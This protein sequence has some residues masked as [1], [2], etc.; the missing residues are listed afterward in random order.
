MMNRVGRIRTTPRR[1][2]RGGSQPP[3]RY[4]PT[5]MNQLG[6]IRTVS[7][8]VPFNRTLLTRNK[9]GR[10]SRPYTGWAV[11]VVW[12]AKTLPGFTQGSRIT[13]QPGA[14]LSAGTARQIT[15]CVCII[16][17]PGRIV[18][19]NTV[20]PAGPCPA[21]FLPDFWK[22]RLWWCP[23]PAGRFPGGYGRRECVPRTGR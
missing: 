12:H 7:D 2:C 18:N 23:W 17:I 8:V 4:N 19:Q 14:P 20:P 16:V 15:I 11:V 22:S 6:Q 3:A 10:L 21:S 5:I 1:N 13:H 9:S